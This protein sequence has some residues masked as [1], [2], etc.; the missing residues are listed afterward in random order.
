MFPLLAAG[1][2]EVGRGPLAGPVVAAAVILDPKRCI[3]GLKDSKQLT[4]KKREYLSQIIQEKALAFAMGE[5]SVLEI[6]TLNILQATL[7]AMQ[8]AINSLS[9]TPQHVW[10]DG[11]HCPK[12][13][14]TAEAIIRG[15]QTVPAISAASILA[16]VYRDC[17]M[18]QLD[19]DYPLYGFAM[20]K[21]YTTAQHLLALK[22]H[23]ITPHHRKSFSPVREVF[24]ARGC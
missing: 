12:L 3:D 9:L 11:N 21:G 18:T 19:K 8:R 10:I 17:Y 15:D 1:V 6:D 2:D 16:K 24:E 4:E 20:N 23:G 22:Q 13:T 14:Q 5:A 7:L